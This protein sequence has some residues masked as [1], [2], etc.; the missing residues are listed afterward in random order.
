MPSIATAGGI[1]LFHVR[2]P[3]Q[4][5]VYLAGTANGLIYRFPTPLF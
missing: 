1:T 4:D 3:T 5:Q 2:F